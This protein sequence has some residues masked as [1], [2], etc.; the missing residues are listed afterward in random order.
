MIST[1]YQTA[2]PDGEALPHPVIDSHFGGAVV[3]RCRSE[4]LAREFCRTLNEP[5]YRPT[6][7][8]FRLVEPTAGSGGRS[9]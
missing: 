7:P 5:F 4:C 8:Q 9:A 1:R 6:P 3:A 2:P